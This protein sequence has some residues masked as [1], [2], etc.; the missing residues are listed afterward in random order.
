METGTLTAVVAEAALTS[1]AGS[2]RGRRRAGSPEGFP[3]SGGGWTPVPSG[4]GVGGRQEP[5]CLGNILDPKLIGNFR[6]V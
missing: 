4:A 1:A 2:G 5:D 6:V 3:G